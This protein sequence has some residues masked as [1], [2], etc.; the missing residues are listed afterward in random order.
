MVKMK[1]S[2]IIDKFVGGRDHRGEMVV[3]AMIG[4]LNLENRLRLGD[5]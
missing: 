4:I 2:D 1:S 3:G 5:G